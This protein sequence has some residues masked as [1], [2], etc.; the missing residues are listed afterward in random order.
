MV[1]LKAQADITGYTY[2]GALNGHHYFFSNCGTT[3]GQA[4][5]AAIEM[6]GYLATIS[7]LEENNF[8]GYW[9][10][11][12]AQLPLPEVLLGVWIGLKGEQGIYEW[13]NGEPVNFDF[14]YNGGEPEPCGTDSD[15]G[16]SIA[17]LCLIFHHL[18]N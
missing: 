17:L 16:Y 8:L 15:R 14:W 10:L 6:G 2:L 3:W 13:T 4:N 1:N 18:Q 5:E 11:N 12:F 9:C 7:S